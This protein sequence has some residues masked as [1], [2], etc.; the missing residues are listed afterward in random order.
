[1]DTPDFCHECAKT[2]FQFSASFSETIPIPPTDSELIHVEMNFEIAGRPVSR[3]V[4]YAGREND[5]TEGP[6]CIARFEITVRACEGQVAN[7]QQSPMD[8]GKDCLTD[9]L[10]LVSAIDQNRL[11]PQRCWQ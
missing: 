9:G 5:A 1:M 6:F 11:K 8:A 10:F 4:V 3:V 2:I 7:N